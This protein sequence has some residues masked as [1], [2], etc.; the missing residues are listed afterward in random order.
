VLAKQMLYNLSHST[1]L[2]ALVIFEIESCFMLRPAW[3]AI[4]LL[5]LSTYLG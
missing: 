5:M 4:L 2:L 1:S 3:T